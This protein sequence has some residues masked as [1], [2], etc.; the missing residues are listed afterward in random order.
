MLNFEFSLS[1]FS[2]S[3]SH[4]HLTKSTVALPEQAVKESSAMSA[5]HSA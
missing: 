1:P 4:T 3:F 5:Y 2:H